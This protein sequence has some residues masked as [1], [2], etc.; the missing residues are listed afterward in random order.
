MANAIRGDISG[1]AIIGAVKGICID[2]CSSYNGDAASRHLQVGARQ[3]SVDG[4]PLTPCL[5][6]DIPGFWRFRW[7]VTAGNRTLTVNTK[8]VSNSV[9]RPTVKIKKNSAI[10][11]NADVIGTAPAGAGWVTLGPVSFSV[12]GTGMVYVELWNNDTMNYASTAYFDHL[13]LT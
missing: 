7:S 6:L 9:M 11:L 1:R 12:S 4:S 2:Q 3:E 5:A 13:I 8:Q 10:G